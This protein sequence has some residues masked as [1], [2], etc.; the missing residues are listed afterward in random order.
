MAPLDLESRLRMLEVNLAT[1]EATVEQR[2]DAGAKQFESQRRVFDEIRHDVAQ[3][4]HDVTPKRVSYLS[5]SALVMS[6]LLAGGGSV[7][8]LSTMMGD[9]PTRAQVDERFT[10]VRQQVEAVADSLKREQ[11][12]TRADLQA[13]KTQVVRDL[14]EIKA[15]VK[16]GRRGP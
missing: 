9:R 4:R 1:L 8:A 12:E 3:V 2:L 5:L 16:P 10:G 11:S 15:N 6:A 7:W 13:L 14:A